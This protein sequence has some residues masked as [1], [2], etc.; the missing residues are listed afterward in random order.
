MSS[1]ADH[2]VAGAASAAEATPGVA[3]V[4][5]NWNDA[6]ATLRCLDALATSDYRNH[7]VIVVDNAS[8][9]GSAQRVAVAA[10]DA[11]LI[12]NDAN[13]GFTGGVNVGIRR[14]METGADYVWLLNSDAITAR[15]VLGRLVEAAEADPRIGL[16]SPVFHDPE[17]P[18][19]VEFCLARFDAASRT[20][21]QT[22]DPAQARDWARNHSDEIVLIGT[23][24]LIRRSLIE[25]IGVL[26][27]QFFAYV[28]DVDYALRCHAAGFR[29]IALADVVVLHK[30]KQPVET[31]SSVA[32]YLHYF[33]TRNYLL[34]WRKLPGSPWLHKASLW[35]LRQRLAQIARMPGQNAAIEAVLAGLWDGVRGIGGPYRP[36]RRP[37]RWLRAT[38]GRHPGFFLALLDGGRSARPETH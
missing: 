24:L 10:P 5:L 20:A 23:A 34:L 7:R 36:E 14:A 33:I 25:T 13:L 19:N 6:D 27:P 22:A 35:F 8:A 1:V 29:T 12:I 26:D 30:F 38:L 15:D 2:Q 31:P 11:E 32:P 9:D 3:V 18:E 28:E 16:V 4:V 17:H 21:S 37:P